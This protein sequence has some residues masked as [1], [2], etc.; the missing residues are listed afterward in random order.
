MYSLTYRFSEHKYDGFCCESNL[1]RVRI[2]LFTSYLKDKFQKSQIFNFE[3][4]TVQILE[5]SDKNLYLQ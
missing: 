2:T 3:G 1:L 4:K 5:K